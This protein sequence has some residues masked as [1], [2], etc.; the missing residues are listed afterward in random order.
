MSFTTNTSERMR[1]DSS[2][3]VGI[4]TTAP[5]RRLH[6]FEGDSTI[7][8][9][10][11]GHLVV[12]N[13]SVSFINLLGGNGSVKG[14]LMSGNS[15]NAD[16]RLTYDDN[17]RNLEFWTASSE[18]MRIDSSGNVGIGI[19]SLSDRKLAVK[20]PGVNSAQICLIDAS[21]SNEVWQVG[22]QADGDGFLVLRTDSGSGTVLFDASG[23][24]Y[25]NGGRS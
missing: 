14:I 17:S 5:D 18:R 16:G 1:I 21:S 4:G 15:T 3:L 13:S 22:Q 25:I 19:A 2:G 6:V 24:N 8:P 23:D 7:T 11:N 9:N 10:S 20:S 12:E